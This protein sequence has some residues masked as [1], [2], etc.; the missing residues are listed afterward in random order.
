MHRLDSRL[1]TAKER[2]SELEHKSEESIQ[3]EQRLKTR[4]EK[5]VTRA[6]IVFENIIIG[7]FPEH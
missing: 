5:R 3:N 1:N 2:I 4:Q 6:E 7:N